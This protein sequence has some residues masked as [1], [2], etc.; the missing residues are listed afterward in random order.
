LRTQ[1]EIGIRHHSF[2]GARWQNVQTGGGGEKSAR[3]TKA[4]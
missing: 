4:P 1:S 3:R 2:F